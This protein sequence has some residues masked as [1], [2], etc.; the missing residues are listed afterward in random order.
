MKC[1]KNRDKSGNNGA[2]TSA[3]L[4]AV[5][6]RPLQRKKIII[7]VGHFPITEVDTQI[8]GISPRAAQSSPCR[9][10][11]LETSELRR[12]E[13]LQFGAELLNPSTAGGRL[14]CGDGGMS[15]APPQKALS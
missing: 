3:R 6:F 13:K 1:I 5:E 8:E 9:R 2:V 7:P 15:A 12:C 14:L 4:H 10:E 11:T